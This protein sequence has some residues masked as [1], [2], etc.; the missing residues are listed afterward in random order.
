[1]VIFMVISMP[2]DQIPE[3][4]LLGLPHADKAVHFLL[5]AIFGVLLILGL[6]KQAGNRQAGTMHIL[7]ALLIGLAYGI[8]TEYYQHC[9]LA[10]RH[11]NIPDIVAN[12]FGTIFGVVL[13]AMGIQP[14]FKK[15]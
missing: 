14:G 3:T 12:A 15:N 6:G 5:F 11:G 1:V 9:C 8:L 10:D 13:M 2:S 4:P 7:M